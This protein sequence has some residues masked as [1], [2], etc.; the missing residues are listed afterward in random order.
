[1]RFVL[2]VLLLV[3]LAGLASAQSQYETYTGWAVDPTP[4]LPDT[5]AHPQLWFGA[6]DLDAIRAKWDDPAYAEVRARV[7]ADINR[8]RSRN[9]ASTDPGD[10]SQMAKAL[11]FAWI[12]DGD[13]VAR[14]RGYEALLLAYQ[15]VPREATEAAFDG[16]NGAIYRATWLQNFSAAYD[17]LHGVL[18][19]EDD[20]TIR[21]ALA[22]ETALL[23]DNMVDGI[24]YAPR[25]H[26]H[27][28]KPGYAIGTAAL[29][30]SDHP[31]AADWLRL[32]LE[33]VNTT[34][35]YQFSA[36]GIYREGSHYWL[37]TLVNG[38]P[39]LWQYREAGVDLF[40]AYQPTFE[41]PVQTR[42]GR[43][44][45]PA[46]ED[47]FPK[48]A[49]THMVAAAYADAPTSLH[50]SAPL[51]EI[52]QWN[53]DTTDF[54]R[55]DYTGATRDVVWSIDEFLTM[56]L[57]IPATEPDVS[58][59]IRL[60]SGQIAFRSDWKGGD[61][62]TR[63]LLFHGVASADNHDHP[64]LLSYTF[65][66][67][68]TPLAV[69][70]GYGPDGFTD[71][72]SDWYLSPRAHNVVTVNGFPV[73]DISVNQNLGP[74]QTVFV[75]GAVFDAAEMV[76]PNNGVMGGATVRRG[77][78][79]LDDEYVAVYDHIDA[80]N[81]ASLQVH[82]HGRGTPT[83][84]GNTATWTAPSDAYGEGGRL[85]VSFVADGPIT[86]DAFDGW[87]SFYFGHEEEQQSVVARRNAAGATFLH[88]LTATPA[89]GSAPVV[90][91]RTAGDLV[92]AELATPTGAWHLATQRTDGARTADRVT[93]DATFAAVGREGDTATRWGLI[94]GTD[95]RWDGAPLLT[96]DLP[97]TVSAD[98][99]EANRQTVVLAPFEGT[100][101]VTVYL[102]PASATAQNV[103]LNGT[104]LPFEALPDG[105]VRFIP[106]APGSLVIT[107]DIASSG[108]AIP[109]AARLGLAVAPNPSAGP[110]RFALDVPTPGA[111]R[112]T[113]FDALGRLV[114]TLA[115]GVLPAAR[116]DLTWDGLVNGTPVAAG[117]YIAVAEAGGQRATTR[118]L[119][120]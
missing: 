24:R 30:L 116:H 15:N 98:L 67:E 54:F 93:T 51:G 60:E 16:E 84:T 40:P 49:P 108:E 47:G 5:E 107:T 78:A 45:M 55:D 33:Q 117:I 92:G 3:P 101:T 82:V 52:L 58:P 91:N 71:D 81:P 43:G 20:A 114:T 70:A 74:E 4:V 50:A 42:T 69:D 27:R 110:V 80:I 95:L 63:M 25:P 12:V 31:S 37:Y 73:R 19:P 65:D 22:E 7:Q 35:R 23:A 48:P 57:S 104:P 36:D 113:V 89:S 21:A 88:T 2:S 17:W 64:D 41:W 90:S 13:I 72:R 56:D 44:W 103:T 68:N 9:P 6:D 10:R 46:L 120:F 14:V 28:S 86:F 94:R 100:P 76:A 75:D 96:S 32:S 87:T 59:T 1:M 115:D 106:T 61:P 62:Q 97:L 105:G 53:W 99:R 11:A 109:E 112:V 26:N 111:V 39:F 8:Y 79:F 102:V 38:I 29:T 34:T 119:R 83:R 18:S 66:A 77:V 85:H 118:L